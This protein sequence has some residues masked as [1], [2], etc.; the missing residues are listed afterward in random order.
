MLTLKRQD[1]AT[2]PSLTQTSAIVCRAMLLTKVPLPQIV[3]LWN[4]WSAARLPWIAMLQLTSRFRD[5]QAQIALASVIWKTGICAVQAQCSLHDQSLPVERSCCQVSACAH[6]HH[7][8]LTLRL[9]AR[10]GHADAVTLVRPLQLLLM[11]PV[12][13]GHLISFFG[14][15]CT[16]ISPR[17]PFPSTPATSACSSG[18]P[19]LS[20]VPE[21]YVPP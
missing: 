4:T 16:D 2:C 11:N 12:P 19:G 20:P 3:S 10:A 7:G 17:S 15:C 5:S 6:A 8:T 14:G 13:N 9:L 18:C 21:Q 1:L